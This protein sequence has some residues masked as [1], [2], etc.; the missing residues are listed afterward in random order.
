MIGG[1]FIKPATHTAFIG[2][3]SAGKPEPYRNIPGDIIIYIGVPAGSFARKVRY[4]KDPDLSG[5]LVFQQILFDFQLH[6][7]F[8]A[9]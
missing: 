8:F 7:I 3:V 2:I 9:I 6:K 4:A 5:L 1:Y